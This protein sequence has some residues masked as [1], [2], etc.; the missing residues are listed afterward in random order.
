MSYGKIN[1]D[2]KGNP[3]CELCGKGFARLGRHVWQSHNMKARD[4]KKM[5]G[6]DVSKGLISEASRRKISKATK[7]N[8]DLVIKKNLLE[9]GKDTRFYKGHAANRIKSPQT[10]IRLKEHIKTIKN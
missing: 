6:L 8:Y 10:I 4:Y 3:V 5:F 2:S 7:K 1:Y 9:K